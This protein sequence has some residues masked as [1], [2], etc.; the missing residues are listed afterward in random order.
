MELKTNFFTPHL[1]AASSSL[2][3]LTTLLWKYFFGFGHGFADKRVG[4]EMHDRVGPGGLDG[5]ENVAVLS[6]G[7][8]QNE[9]RARVHSGAMPFGEIVVNGDLMSRIEELLGADGPDVT[10]AAGDEYV[11]AI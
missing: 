8:A 9:L 7:F 6:S 3:P 11:H 5:F 10:R 4:G 2:R 1:T